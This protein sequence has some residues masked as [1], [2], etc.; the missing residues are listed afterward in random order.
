MTPHGIM[1]HHF[2]G[3]GHPEGMGSIGAD[4]LREVI[5]RF[6]SRIIQAPAFHER[7]ISGTLEPQDICLTFDDTLFSQYEIAEPILAHYGIKAFWFVHTAPLIYPGWLG[8]AMFRDFQLEFFRNVGELHRS[9]RELATEEEQAAPMD[10]AHLAE[11]DF[12][13]P[14][15]RTYRHFR[16]V[17]LGPTR[18]NV[19]MSDLMEKLEYCPTLPLWMTPPQVR[20]LYVKGHSLGLHSHSH[21]RNMGELPGINQIQEYGHNQYTLYHTLGLPTGHKFPSASHPSNS[22]NSETLGVLRSKGVQL[23][24]R[25]NMESAS[26]PGEHLLEMPREDVANL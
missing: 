14:E 26:W 9:L 25:A 18:F 19:L 24:F 20:D 23:A 7:A 5:E 13:T 4:K 21:P 16:D 8:P 2:H 10:L 17:V 12:Y 15:D 3:E 11:F 1:F 22:Y 6:K